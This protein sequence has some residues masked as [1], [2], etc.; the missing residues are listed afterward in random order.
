MA[1]YSRQLSSTLIAL[2]IV[3]TL[4]GFF[5]PWIPH[6]AAGLALTG[7]ELGEWIKFAPQVRDGTAGLRRADF[8]F[9][10]VLATLGLLALAAGRRPWR[11][12]HWVL[13]A[14][15]ALVALI[16]FPLLEE[17]NNPA[18]VRANLARLALV[19]GGWLAA[20]FVAGKR[21][22]PA[23][24]RGATLSLAAGAGL[25]L[26]SLAFRTAE[27][28]IEGLYNQLMDPGV[29]YN[30]TR[31]GMLLLLVGGIALLSPEQKN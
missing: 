18:G 25:V 8:H 13:T 23:H 15:A 11:W 20:G 1:R 14:L 2:G 4:V 10:P 17:I 16:P 19:L 27:P 5:S 22:L 3:L 21:Y 26:V 24:L 30:L 6:R 12:H 29:G 31:G 28:I 9:P 7:F